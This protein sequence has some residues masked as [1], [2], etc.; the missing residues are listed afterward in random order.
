MLANSSF[1]SADLTQ[2]GEAVQSNM[3][4]TGIAI[5][6]AGDVEAEL[7]GIIAGI[8]TGLDSPV[9]LANTVLVAN[10]SGYDPVQS[11]DVTQANTVANS[12]AVANQ[13]KVIG[14]EAGIAATIGSSIIF[15]NQVDAENDTIVPAQSIHPSMSL[16]QTPVASDISIVD[17][18]GVQ[19][20]ESESSQRSATTSSLA[21]RSTLGT[22]PIVRA[23]SKP[24][25][26]TQSRVTSRSSTQ[27]VWKAASLASL[28]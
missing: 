28:P 13:G 24:L 27:A 10:Y 22:T 15:G 21:T 1:S 5:A 4:A 11:A 23:R 19:G 17:I 26:Q 8:A 9:L 12:I 16:K 7:G 2:F 25:R 18:G 14:G 3:L 6:N 20:G